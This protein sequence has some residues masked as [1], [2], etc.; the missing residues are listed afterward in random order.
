L[1]FKHWIKIKIQLTANNFSCFLTI[2]SV[3]Y[4][5]VDSISSIL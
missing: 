5:F 4:L 2:R 3:L 1:S